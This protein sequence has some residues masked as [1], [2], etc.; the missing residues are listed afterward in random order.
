M[1]VTADDPILVANYVFPQPDR[2][3]VPLSSQDSLDSEAIA[4]LGHSEAALYEVS[5][6]LAIP[7]SYSRLLDPAH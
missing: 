7:N 3:T 2:C 4:T 5:S 6:S 1:S